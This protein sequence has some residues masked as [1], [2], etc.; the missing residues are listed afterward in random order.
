MDLKLFR[1]LNPSLFIHPLIRI[2]SIVIKD[3][4]NC[5][6]MKLKYRLNTLIFIQVIEFLIEFNLLRLDLHEMLFLLYS[7]LI[8]FLFLLFKLRIIQL[9]LFLFFMLGVNFLLNFIH[10]NFCVVLDELLILFLLLI[11]LLLNGQLSLQLF[12]LLY[13]KSIKHLRFVGSNLV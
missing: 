5:L 8:I 11:I 3:N 4:R 1:K 6:L 13:L 7:H 12:L 10:F 9:L 2:L